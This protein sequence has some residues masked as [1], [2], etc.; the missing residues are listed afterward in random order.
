[1]K[2]NVLAFAAHP[3]DAELGCSGTLALH[4]SLG[5]T[6][7]IVDLTAGE[8]GTR[9]SVETR[10]QESALATEII[11]L[12]FR[13]NLGFKDG[14]FRNDEE[15]QME[16]IKVI[17]QCQPDIVLANAI[18][19]RHP[20]HGRAAE[21]VRDA[22]FYAGLRKIE[23]N[24]NGQVQE[25]WRPKALYHYIQFMPVPYDL[26]V[27][28]SPFMELKMKSILAYGSQFYNPDSK[29]PVTVISSKKFIDNVTERNSDWGRICGVEYAEAFTTSRTPAVK[30]LF[31]VF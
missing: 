21:L 4:K 18:S 22:C 15:H 1:L 2:I 31:D 25:A 11:G 14:F 3:D 5:Q 19:D 6:T 29:E 17:R 30:S 9:G 16:V 27:D 12:D 24:V 23:T 20:D 10:Q 7:G 26:L 28:I 8:L 13:T